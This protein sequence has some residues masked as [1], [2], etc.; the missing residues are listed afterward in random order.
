MWLIFFFN[1][2]YIISAFAS[3]KECVSTCE[4]KL[5]TWIPYVAYIPSLKVKVVDDQK[6]CTVYN[7][8]FLCATIWS[9]G[10]IID[11]AY[12]DEHYKLYYYH[13]NLYSSPSLHDMT[14][15]SYR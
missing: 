13:A 1:F 8:L 14:L 12:E 15:Y 6:T 7:A 10:T 9:S 2:E 11:G 4:V 3:G 5:K